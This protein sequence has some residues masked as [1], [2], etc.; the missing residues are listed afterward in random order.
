MWSMKQG[1]EILWTQCEVARAWG[2]VALYVPFKRVLPPVGPG[3][4]Y[5]E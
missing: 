3:A 2:Y 1:K 4:V 5:A